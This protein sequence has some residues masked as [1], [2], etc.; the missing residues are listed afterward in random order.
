MKT[1]CADLFGTPC[2]TLV[3]LLLFGGL[4]WLTWQC[5]QWGW[6]D[7][8]FEADADRCRESLQGACWGVI[9]EKIRPILW[10]R[11]PF[12]AQWRSAFSSLILLL[13]LCVSAWPAFWRRSLA[14]AWLVAWGA[15]IVLMRGGLW[16]LTEVPTSR[17]G[18]VTLT[19]IL[20]TL[21]LSAALP[22]GVF[23]ALG[24]R[25]GWP[26]IR[27][28][29]VTYIEVIRGVPLIS[30]LFMATFMLP[31]LFPQSWRL[32]VLL[33]VLIGLVM[34]VAAYIA[35]VIR[36]GLQSI[37]RGQIEAAVALGLK[38]WQVQ[39][40]VV[41]P[42]ALRAVIPALMNNVVGTL[43]DSSLVTVIGLYELTGALSLALGGDPVW[44]PFYLEGYVFITAVYFSLCFSLSRYSNWVERRLIGTS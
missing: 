25:S 3:S 29:C 5:L 6:I 32:D 44:R 14:L 1:W 13:L 9:R 19:L 10:G 42:Q 43:K 36:G 27:T 11:F 20:A 8:I 16:G 39:A 4:A 28:P 26:L 31:L 33:R 18:G 15:V 7:A 12:E 2:R 21:A 41:L 37:P 38:P 17:W 40:Y 24:R 35:E 30:V 23:L 22:L 34:F